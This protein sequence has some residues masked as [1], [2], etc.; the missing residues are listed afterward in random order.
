MS[1][2]SDA[3]PSVLATVVRR[4]YSEV[5]NAG[6][7]DV[8]AELIHPEFAYA[9]RPGL[10]GPQAKLAA[11]HTYRAMFP[12][13][14]FSVEEMVVAPDRV[15]VRTTLTCTDT[16]GLAGRAPTGRSLSAWS[17]EFFGFRDGLIVSD[18]V[19]NDWL[20]LFVQAGAVADPWAR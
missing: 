9:A 2:R 16:G 4:L 1:D 20:G 14:R 3:D 15:A 13:A 11:V 18:W 19:G 8:A 12:D 17:V 7:D 6:R 10:R 5:W